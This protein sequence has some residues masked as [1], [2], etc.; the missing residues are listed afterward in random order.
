MEA[1]ANPSH[2]GDLDEQ[3][4]KSMARFM[5]K[6]GR[7]MGEDLGDDFDEAIGTMEGDGMEPSLPAMDEQRP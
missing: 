3:D 7:E 2:L 1:L 4:P 5:K 6:M